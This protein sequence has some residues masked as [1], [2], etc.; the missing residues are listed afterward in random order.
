VLTEEIE[1][2]QELLHRFDAGSGYAQTDHNW[3]LSPRPAP[4]PVA[5][6]CF[7]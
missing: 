7:R 2:R 4:T 3:C 5:H 6:R 1:I